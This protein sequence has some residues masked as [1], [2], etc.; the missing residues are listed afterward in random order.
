MYIVYEPWYGINI[1]KANTLDEIIEQLL[2]TYLDNASKPI[3]RLQI[4]LVLNDFDLNDSD[5]MKLAIS[6]LIDLGVKIEYI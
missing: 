6:K 1:P 2:E 3:T 4:G 5:N